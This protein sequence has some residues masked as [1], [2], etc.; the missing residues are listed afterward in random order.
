MH[1]FQPAPGATTYV[2][3]RAQNA[4][5]TGSGYLHVTN[6]GRADFNDLYLLSGTQSAS[7]GSIRV[8]GNSTLTADHLFVSNGTTAVFDGPGT[9]VTLNRLFIGDTG[10]FGAVSQGSGSVVTV[11]NGATVTGVLG[12]Y[13]VDQGTLVVRNWGSIQQSGTGDNDVNDYIGG[14]N[15]SGKLVI[16]DENNLGSPLY[17]PGNVDLFFYANNKGTI[18]INH[19]GTQSDAYTLK[20]TFDSRIYD[21]IYTMNVYSG[22]TIHSPY[23]IGGYIFGTQ[24]IYGGTFVSPIGNYVDVNIFNGTYMGWSAT[25]NIV[26]T[27]GEFYVRP[28]RSVAGVPQDQVVDGLGSLTPITYTSKPGSSIHFWIGDTWRLSADYNERH[29]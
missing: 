26:N 22:Y 4:I 2:G 27:G 5:N 11:S 9:E 18:I 3:Y 6:G 17:K 7:N 24:N 20:A 15:T 23:A 21:T 12:A 16:G 14:E 1:S 25:S 10:K 8:D 13:Q 28:P 29:L 19:T